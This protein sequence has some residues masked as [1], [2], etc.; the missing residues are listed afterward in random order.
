M[1]AALA[2][3]GL[4]IGLVRLRRMLRVLIARDLPPA[5]GRRP[6]V[7]DVATGPIGIDGAECARGGTR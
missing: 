7:R 5:T 2:V 6:V 4:P 3:L 1:T